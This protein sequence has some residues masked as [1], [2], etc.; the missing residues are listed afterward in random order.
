MAILTTSSVIVLSYFKFQKLMEFRCMRNNCIQESLSCYTQWRRVVF[1]L[2][3]VGK[4][5]F[6]SFI[7]KYF[8][9]S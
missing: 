4:L 5:K 2:G 9:T 7:L 3:A 1:L 8:K 6:Q